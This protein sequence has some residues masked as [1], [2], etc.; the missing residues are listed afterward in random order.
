M[1]NDQPELSYVHPSL[2]DMSGRPVTIR[3]KT[4]YQGFGTYPWSLVRSSAGGARHFIVTWMPNQNTARFVRKA[5]T[6]TWINAH[7]DLSHSGKIPS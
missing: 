2:R 1:N 7:R 4:G 3:C 5:D 6:T